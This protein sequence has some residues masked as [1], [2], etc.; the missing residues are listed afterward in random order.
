MKTK[1]LNLVPLSFLLLMITL[2]LV[3]CGS[4][5]FREPIVVPTSTS[6]PLPSATSTPTATNT[7]TA[8]STA[9]PVTLTAIFH[10]NLYPV[11]LN[12]PAGW[13]VSEISWQ[14]TDNSTEI[15]I[16]NDDAQLTVVAKGTD[17]SVPSD[18][19]LMGCVGAFGEMF[20]GQIESLQTEISNIVMIDGK[21][22]AIA[23]YSDSLIVACYVND[24]SV[25]IAFGATSPENLSGFRQT[26]EAVLGSLEFGNGDNP[27][28][29]TKG[30]Y[31]D[32]VYT[33]PDNSFSCDFSDSLG[34]KAVGSLYENYAKGWGT[35]W[36][37]YDSQTK[38]RSALV[39]EIL[40]F[41][42]SYPKIPS[43]VGQLFATPEKQQDGLKAFL[44]TFFLPNRQKAIPGTKITYEEAVSKGILF[45]I[46]FEP[47]GSDTKWVQGHTDNHFDSQNGYY[48]FVS[49]DKYF[50]V[51][52]WAGVILSD[53]EIYTPMPEWNVDLFTRSEMQTH[54][55]DLYDHCKF[56]S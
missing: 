33:S 28:Q 55:K 26:F 50:L 51:G 25:V 41:D 23:V 27:I 35:V 38:R 7:P 6:T 34:P 39:N 49:G 31:Q 9:T 3:S 52:F 4:G 40:Y 32:Y 8:T 22:F 24:G 2:L 10:S 21:R 14:D 36:T 17:P 46:L 20:L 16:V 53:K 44:E 37:T 47:H 48:I 18:A 42:R 19:E 45:A 13:H 12:Y 5:R 56:Q 30:T 54:V 1:C 29:A 43:E 11:S 15:D